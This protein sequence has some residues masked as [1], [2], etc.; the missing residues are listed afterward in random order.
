[1][2]IARARA[3]ADVDVVQPIFPTAAA[4][5]ADRSP[6]RRGRVH[7]WAAAAAIVATITALLAGG[8]WFQERNHY[9]TAHAEQRSWRMP[10]G[11]TVHLNS[12]SEIR[13]RFDDRQRRVDLLRGQ[14]LFQVA[15]DAR[16]PFWV[17]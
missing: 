8:W 4:H 11:S 6:R 16:R 12:S 15:K 2:L 7:V 14:A 17:Y 9:Q 13:I 1:V 10:D 5:S 3:E